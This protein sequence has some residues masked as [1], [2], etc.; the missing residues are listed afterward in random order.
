[1]ANTESQHSQY[2]QDR[3]NRAGSH[4]NPQP[5]VPLG[6]CVAIVDSIGVN[7]DE[8]TFDATL[9]GD[10]GIESIDFLDIVFRIEKA[11]EIEIPRSDLFPE[12][13]L[14]NAD[15]VTDGKVNEAGLAALGERI[16]HMDLT[17]FKQDSYLANFGNC[18]TV[19]DLARYLRHQGVVPT[20]E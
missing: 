6:I 3:L 18:L 20:N 10:L 19:G 14:T 17:T 16:P 13:I 2:L 15:Y 4:F 8:V 7:D 12:D 9:V 11:Y 5:G 1:M